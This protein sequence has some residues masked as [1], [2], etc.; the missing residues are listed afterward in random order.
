MRVPFGLTFLRFRLAFFAPHTQVYQVCCLFF[1]IL[2]Y[3]IIEVKNN[4]G[5][6]QCHNGGFGK[7]MNEFIDLH[8]STRGFGDQL[9]R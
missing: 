8:D 5:R 3:E 4:V 2:N 7:V 9:Q 1:N 6:R